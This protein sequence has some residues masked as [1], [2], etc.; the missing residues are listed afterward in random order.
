[1]PL[2]E[3]ERQV[4]NP[5]KWL[6]DRPAQKLFEDAPTDAWWVEHEHRLTR[7]ASD[8]QWSN[9]RRELSSH[10]MLRWYGAPEAASIHNVKLRADESAQLEVQFRVLLTNWRKETRHVS[11]LRKMVMNH[12]YQAIIGM[13][14]DALPFIFR[15]LRDSGGHWYW[16]LQSITS[17]VRKKRWYGRNVSLN[18]DFHL[19]ANGLK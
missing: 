16:A 1:M 15:E 10:I 19:D 9:Q 17:R 11:S 3:I 4:G 13:G 14:K 6:D 12:N 5:R 8:P 7:A 18:S 2:C